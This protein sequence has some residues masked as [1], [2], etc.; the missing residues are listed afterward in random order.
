MSSYLRKYN[1]GVAYPHVYDEV[2]DLLL[3]LRAPC[4]EIQHELGINRLSGVN[5]HGESGDDVLWEHGHKCGEGTE[6]LLGREQDIQQSQRGEMRLGELASW[7][8]FAR[9]CQDRQAWNGRDGWD[10]GEGG[11]GNEADVCGSNL[12]KNGQKSKRGLQDIFAYQACV[13]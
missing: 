4:V 13:R 3:C 1:Y 10:S 5:V 12:C 8:T 6:S 2:I 9:T 11:W 7:Q